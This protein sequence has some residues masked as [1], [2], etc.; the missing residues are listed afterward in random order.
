MKVL[1]KK[2][3]EASRDF[4]EV[5]KPSVL[6]E[7]EG[8]IKLEERNLTNTSIQDPAQSRRN[9]K[10]WKSHYEKFSPKSIP[11]EEK[12]ALWKRAKKLK[13][14]FCEGMLS[15]DEIHPVRQI[16]NEK[17]IQVVVD[18]TKMASIHSVE[19]QS[20]WYQRN[21]SKIAEFKNIMRKLNPNNPMAGDI[22]RFRPVRSSR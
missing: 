5:A 3:Y 2:S 4:S 8:N 15:Q 10:A 13:D 14:E 9:L 20:A 22:E 12:N 7:L 18:D 11:P 6:K 16:H 1:I 19:R 17:G 21:A